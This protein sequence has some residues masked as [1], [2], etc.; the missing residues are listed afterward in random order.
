MAGV[1]GGRRP[2]GSGSIQRQTGT[3]RLAV[4]S[5]KEGGRRAEYIGSVDTRREAERLIEDWLK[6]NGGKHE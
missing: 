1:V 6:A 4:W 5:P 2:R 3:H